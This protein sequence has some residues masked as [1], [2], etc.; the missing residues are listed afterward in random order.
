MG[1]IRRDEMKTRK[2]QTA[3]HWKVTTQTTLS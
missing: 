1:E 3:C 2:L